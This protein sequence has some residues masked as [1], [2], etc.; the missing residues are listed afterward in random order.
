MNVLSDR[1]LLG[2]C[3]WASALWSQPIY[4]SDDRTKGSSYVDLQCR[5]QRMRQS[6]IALLFI[7]DDSIAFVGS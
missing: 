4:M 3:S 5:F 6:Q 7:H 1:L 2:D